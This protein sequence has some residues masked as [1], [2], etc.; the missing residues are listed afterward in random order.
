MFILFSA[1]RDVQ[2]KFGGTVMGESAMANTSNIGSLVEFTFNVSHLHHPDATLNH[3]AL[4]FI[5]NM[6]AAHPQFPQPHPAFEA[7]AAEV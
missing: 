7:K 5:C 4:Y 3:G 2:S 1:K 6:Y